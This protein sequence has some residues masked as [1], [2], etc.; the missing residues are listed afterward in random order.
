VIRE[1]FQTS[2]QAHSL[3]FLLISVVACVALFIGIAVNPVVGFLLLGIGIFAALSIK[4]YGFLHFVVALVLFELILG[5]SGRVYQFNDFFS[6]RK[7]LF[8]LIWALFLLLSA[9]NPH[10]FITWFRSASCSRW[11]SLLGVATLLFFGFGVGLF[12]GNRLDYII[13]DAS[14]FTFITLC[15]PIG[16][17]SKIEKIT[18]KFVLG[19]VL[20]ASA[21]FGLLKGVIF[22]G[23]Q[24]GY[25][26]YRYLVDLLQSEANQ[27][28]SVRTTT[29]IIRMAT[30]GD[31]FFVFAFPLCVAIGVSTK[32]WQTRAMAFAAAGA[33][34]WGLFASGTRGCWLASFIGISVLITLAK[35]GH[36]LK[37]LAL[38]FTGAIF[39]LQLFP[40]TFKNTSQ[41]IDLAFNTREQGNVVRVEQA[42]ILI[43][44]GLEH[45]FIGNGFGH[46][47]TNLTRS[48]QAPYSFE[49]EWLALFMKMGIL[50][51]A[52]WVAF[53]GWLLHTLL[54]FSKSLPDPLDSMIARGI[55]GG[56]VG[57]LAVSAANPYFSGAAGM[58]IS[59]V[60]VVVA[61]L[62]GQE[63]ALARSKAALVAPPESGTRF[64]RVQRVVPR[65]ISRPTKY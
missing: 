43:D 38:V 3:A 23:A 53:F 44:A 17:F 26:D 47:L 48:D 34:V 9:S 57:V 24:L 36:R 58:G 61:D 54:K 18:V 2:S 13:N 8:I 35:V 5:G 4:Q 28:V 22:S 33:I 1:R 21:I 55:C 40:Q 63:V 65:Q 32:R 51:S 42:G 52:I 29:G 15:L 10:R 14:G 60:A 41:L 27:T 62:F 31:V 16:F 11:A 64:A 12:R 37:I 59:A 19:V 39:V 49:L 6:I 25:F 7:V 46:T 50:G 30:I 45:P 20:V 56:F